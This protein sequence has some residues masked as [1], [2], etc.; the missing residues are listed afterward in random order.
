MAHL[1]TVLLDLDGTLADTLPDLGAALNRAL[2][3]RGLRPISL[4]ALRPVVSSGARAMVQFALGP[5]AA[6][7]ESESVYER[8]LTLYGSEIAERTR[9]FPGMETVL[10]VVERRELSWGIV[11]NKVRSFTEP[12]VAMLGLA[13]RAACVVSGDS[14]DVQKPHPGPLLLACREA[15]S[16]PEQCVYV[17]DAQK[18]VIAARRAGMRSIVAVYG[19]IPPGEDP[20]GWG[21]DALID[22][23]RALLDWLNVEAGNASR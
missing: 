4:Q 20:A 11:T 6:A 18:D 7:A 5:D 14:L 10:E 22:S 21:A 19:Y 9:L 17:G 15:E 8:F 2:T 23:P 13:E 12:L 16:R 1:R 3:E